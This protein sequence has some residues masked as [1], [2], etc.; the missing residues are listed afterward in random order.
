MQIQVLGGLAVRLGAGVLPPGTPKQ[1]TVLA[2][3]A[4]NPG[5]LV[6][7]DQLVDELWP[8]GPPHSAVPNVRTYAANLRRSIE[9]MVPAREVLIRARDG[10]RL[11]VEHSA[12][13]VFAFQAE[14]AEARRL[15]RTDETAAVDVLSCALPIWQGPMLTGVPL[16]PALSAQVAAATEDRMLAAEL[17]AELKI[18]LGG[19]DD[20][21]PALRE[22]LIMQPLREPAHLLLMRALH[23]RGDH[24]GAIAAYT[25][26]QRTLREQLNVDPG[27]GMRQLYL[28]IVEHER[29]SR[30]S[31][32]AGRHPFEV[33]APTEPVPTPDALPRGLAD[34]VGRADIIEHLLSETSRVGKL[35]AAVHLIDGMAGSGKT[36]LAVHVAGKLTGGYP[37]AQLF[38]DLK[39][40]D[41]VERVDPSTALATL[42]RQ[43]GVP[44]GRI[45]PEFGERLILWRR[46]LA[47]RRVIIVL[48][49][50]ADAEQ[51]R[52]LL[53]TAPGSVVLVTS[54]RRII[55]LD[56]GPPVSLSVMTPAE[57]V[58]LLRSSAG[59]QRVAADPEAAIALVQQCGGLPLAI[60][61][62]G[63]RLA[64]RPTWRLVDLTALLADN[65]RRLDHLAAGD[66]SVAG[67]FAV[68]YDPLT[69]PVKRLFRLL[70]VHPGDD[71]GVPAAA[72]LS[73]LPFG[74]TVDALDDLLEC[75]LVEEIGPGRYRM[76]DLIRQYAHEL[77]IQHDCASTRGKALSDLSDLMLQ[78][79]FAVVDNLESK[80]VRR[81]VSL[82]RPRRADLLNASGV[83]TE[84][85]MEVERANLM[86]LVERSREWGHHHDAWRLARL[87][88]RFLYVR[89]YFDDIIFTHQHGL[90]AAKAAKDD[91]AVACMHNYLASAHLRTGNYGEAL[92]HVS[93]AVS[94]AE[95]GGDLRNVGRYRTNLVAVHWIR[96]D[97]EDAV[98]V[99]LD[100]LRS[101]DVYD[102][103]EV[104]SFLPNIG[105]ALTLLGRYD[106]ALRLHRLHL[107]VGR[108]VGSQFHLLNALSH[109]G[110]VKCRMAKYEASMRLLRAAL[111][112]RERTGHRY[113]ESEVR[114][115][116]GIALRGLGR[117]DEA[118]LQHDAAR[119]LAVDSGEAHVEAAAMNDLALTLARSADTERLIGLHGEALRVATRI[120]HPYEQGR[121][122][123]G[124]GEHLLVTDRAEA[125]RHWERALAIFRRMG[126][127]EQFEIERRLAE[128]ASPAPSAPATPTMPAPHRQQP[129][130][131]P[132]AEGHH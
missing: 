99:G 58:A 87:L 6:S 43:L 38:I 9:A 69:G 55:G 71:F 13:D 124:L 49:N 7:V 16:G 113:A 132:M 74:E 25:T 19:Y 62:A 101:P 65:F 126:V 27:T 116:L 17:F 39:G 127:P 131:A 77:S 12:V 119:Q 90:A 76:H 105:L 3:L 80:F 102:A 93:E 23:L 112:M 103:D 78:L 45:T 86:S 117:I 82:G 24:A 59:G 60:R 10:Y 81:H 94:I 47:R 79:A 123:A 34:F 107:Y 22:L 120:A 4:C 72:A 8:D 63:S 104:P 89:G 88:W 14:V 61:L 128:T 35:T 109:I 33:I 121:A 129:N 66:R 42:L 44:G 84:E 111:L 100:G 48:D 125:R 46:E 11:D 50:A 2:M 5:R 54:R 95:R 28:R 75:H 15:A 118:V 31:D 91:N 51:V 114:N 68:S 110:A 26:A 1:Q 57:G 73:G 36:S 40:H 52:P 64:H 32:P 98:R 85:W 70:S 122:L 83:S 115:D 29:T 53:P 56:V 92:K 21:L 96:G 67:A 41:S 30:H 108:Q 97:L 106:E 20:A 130:G 18:R 37:D